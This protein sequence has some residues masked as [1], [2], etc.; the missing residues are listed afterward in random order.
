M[1][2]NPLFYVSCFALAF[3]AF[4]HGSIAY[5][6]YAEPKLQTA[7]L[8]PSTYEELNTITAAG[9]VMVAFA[10]YGAVELRRASIALI[11]VLHC[12]LFGFMLDDGLVLHRGWM[13]AGLALAVIAA[14]AAK[15]LRD[16]EWQRERLTSP[17]L[18]IHENDLL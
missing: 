11:A 16:Y 5:W 12:G 15:L 14:F 10:V 9:L 2:R 4:I 13:Q 7:Y 1:F 6:L 8:Y 18:V 17:R 3:V